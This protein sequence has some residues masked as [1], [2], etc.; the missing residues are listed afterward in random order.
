MP[1]PR[2]QKVTEEPREEEADEVTWERPILY[3][4]LDLNDGRVLHIINLHLKSRL[5]SQIKGQKVST[6]T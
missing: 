3:T 2:Y 5:A 4:K 6:Y 1:A